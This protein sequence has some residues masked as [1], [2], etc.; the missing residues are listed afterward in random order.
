MMMSRLLFWLVAP[1]CAVGLNLHV[2]PAA[3]SSVQLIDDDRVARADAR[4]ADEAGVRMLRDRL[5]PRPGEGIR[6]EPEVF[7]SSPNN[8]V[9]GRGSA[10]QQAQLRF[11]NDNQTFRFDTTLNS[12]ADVNEDTLFEQELVNGAVSGV[13]RFDVRIN[14]DEPV[15]VRAN[16]TGNVREGARVAFRAF[17][18][19]RFDFTLEPDVFGQSSDSFRASALLPAGTHRIFAEAITAAGT[20]SRF[21]R[22]DNG[23]SAFRF[24]VSGETVAR[25]G[26]VSLPSPAAIGPGAML[27][28]ALALKRPRRPRGLP[29]CG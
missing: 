27:L 16:G 14:S 11:A 1:V 8:D 18:D 17:G 20:D 9:S 7:G 22:S 25:S 15:R 23:T 4:L 13:S 28:A 26:V 29:S 12:R 6:L 24:S 5:V 10:L 3:G 2:P 19:E 21:P